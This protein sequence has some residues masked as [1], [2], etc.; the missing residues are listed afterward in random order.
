MMPHRSEAF[1]HWHS[2][3]RG[4]CVVQ[5]EHFN[6]HR[7]GGPNKYIYIAWSAVGGCNPRKTPCAFV[8]AGVEVK[9][10]RKQGTGN[11]GRPDKWA[12]SPR[13]QA[14]APHLPP[15]LTLRV[16][17]IQ[18]NCR[19]RGSKQ[20]MRHLQRS[21]GNKEGGREALSGDCDGNASPGCLL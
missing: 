4:S 2:Q 9:K 13:I 1:T 20:T 3:I 17:L 12:A 21:S 19:R 15:P 16:S 18:A 11:E 5:H 6:C 10:K 8:R 7:I 14:V